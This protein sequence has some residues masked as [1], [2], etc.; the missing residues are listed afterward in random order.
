LIDRINKKNAIAGDTV[1]PATVFVNAR[2]HAIWRRREVST[3]ASSLQ[4]EN[5]PPVLEGTLL[6]PKEAEFGV[7]QFRKIN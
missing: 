4:Y 6:N 3:S 2:T 1:C 7:S 5:A